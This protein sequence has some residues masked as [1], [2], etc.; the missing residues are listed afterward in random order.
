MRTLLTALAVG[1][2]MSLAG[3]GGAY[4]GLQVGS[5]QIRDNSVRSVDV[6]D[7]TMAG[8]DLRP[9]VRDALRRS[10]ALSGTE[11]VWTRWILASDSVGHRSTLHCPDGKVALS[12]VSNGGRLRFSAPLFDEMD[13]GVPPTGWGWRI[14]PTHPDTT[15]QDEEDIW[16]YLVC[17]DG[18]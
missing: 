12:G 6:R 3:A 8:R 7:G 10:G 16:Q 9:A 17:A 4:A 14:D 15:G 11:V 5:A 2:A 13:D 18:R 1:G